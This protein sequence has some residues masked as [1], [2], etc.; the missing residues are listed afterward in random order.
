MPDVTK[1]QETCVNFLGVDTG[2]TFT[3]FVLFDGE[4]LRIHKV[5]ST[6]AAPEQAILQGIRDLGL[7]DEMLR[8]VHGSTVATNAVLEGKGVRTLFITNRGFRDLL[9]I[10]RQ[11][12]AELYNLQPQV[13]PPPVPRELCVETGGRRDAAGK[14][15]D[16]LTEED[17][18][19]LAR[20]VQQEQPR[21]VA[22]N[23]LF[24]WKDG[25]DERRIR[26]A[27]PG[28][29]FVS[30]SSEVLPEIREYERGIATW[31]NAWVGPL[32]EGYV[33]RLHA[34]L[35]RA[36][37]SIIQSSGDTIDA[38]RAGRQAV[39]M[40]LSGP[41]GGLVGATWLGGLSGHERLLT[42]DMGGTSTDVSLIDGE[43]QLTNE[44]RIGRWPV[45]V[46]MVDMQTIGA[47]GGS[48]ARVDAGGMLQV[49]PESAGADPGP[50]CYGQG[51]TEVTVS[52]ANL[53]L[54][55]LRPGAF[56]GGRMRLDAEAA[57][58]AMQRLAETMGCTAIE[59]AEGVIRVANEHMAAALR[60]ISVERGVDP[61]EYRLVSFGGAGGLHVC[62]LAEALGMRRA[63]V[64]VHAGV[65]SALGMLA[66][67]PGRELSQTWQ[68]DLAQRDER[69]LEHAFGKLEQ[70]AV[71]ELLKEGFGRERLVASYSLDLRYRGQSNTLN[72]PW[73]GRAASESAFHALHEQRYGHRLDVP[74]EMLNL[75]LRVRA[76]ASGLRLEPDSGVRERLRTDVLMP[77][78]DAPVPQF[79]RASLCAGDHIDGPALIVEEVS[80]TWL[81]D[82]WRCHVDPHGNL[83]LER[84]PAD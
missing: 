30:I 16:P 20:I 77:G 54:G 60:M 65:L 23:L 40:L 39:R 78:Y 21:A 38:A 17:L 56:L 5:L 69:D 31:L 43:P 76:E 8:L 53:V 84:E 63:M 70:K 49:G 52:D 73:E 2:G 80:T 61:G 59:A 68:G 7:S 10:G 1:R 44:G 58:A 48:I 29:L 50:A 27:L 9:S 37:V 55:R 28:N 51:G 62:A 26:D 45:A 18:A 74:V 24:S 34:A 71:S 46:S 42:F 36:S 35:P 19:E 67:R 22:V 13:L 66:T 6:P 75:R 12:R 81:S 82:V 3:D 11:A 64:P 57:Q 79:E 83:L 15:I 14:I 47:G 33:Q 32:V 41:A 4:R 72:I 25:I